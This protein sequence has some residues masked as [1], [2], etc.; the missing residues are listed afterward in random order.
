M[1]SIFS[2]LEFLDKNLDKTL[3]KIFLTVKSN[4]RSWQEFQDILHW[5]CIE[6]FPGMVSEFP[7]FYF[8]NLPAFFK[9]P[10]KFGGNFD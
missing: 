6:F 8:K 7:I 5:V 3:V 4:S 10:V 9:V 2:P 1:N